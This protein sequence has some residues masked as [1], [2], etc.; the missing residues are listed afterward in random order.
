MSKAQFVPAIGEQFNSVWRRGLKYNGFDLK[1]F[2]KESHFE[3]PIA[4]QCGYYGITGIGKT[5][6]DYRKLVGFPDDKIL[7]TDSAGFQMASFR[8]RGEKCEIE[9]IDSLRWQEQNGNIC[10]NLDIPPTLDKV[11]TY[12]EFMDALN[13]SIKNFE[14]FERERKNYD[15]KLYNVLHGETLELMELWYSKVKHFKFD[16]WATGVKPPYDPMIQAMA[17]VFLWEKGELDKDSCYGLHIF[18]TSGKNVVPT[19]VYFASK[20]QGKLV[21]YDSSSYNVGSIYRTYYMPFDIGPH[22][23]FGDKFSKANPHLKELPCE[24]P[25]CKSV[26]SIDDLNTKD[27]YAGTLLSLHNMHQYIYYNNMLNKIVHE[28]ELFMNYLRQVNDCDKTVK[29]IEFIDF[30]ME[31]GVKNAVEKFRNDLI[32]QDLHK[33]DQASI[34]NF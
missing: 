28:K 18:G 8:K 31:H 16:G 21:T 5:N 32:P 7:I 22:F 12:E 33:S 1:F 6:P 24:C 3:H 9:P 26:K 2:T 23:F 14:L 34:W 11:P 25:V 10:M 17:L 13:I 4:L 15:M 29:S 27:I 19:I 20:L 30:A